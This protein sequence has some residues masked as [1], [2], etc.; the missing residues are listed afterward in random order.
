MKQHFAGYYDLSQEQFRRL[1]TDCVFVVDTNVLLDMYRLSPEARESMYNTLHKLKARLW[2]PYQVAKEYHRNI[3]VVILGQ[4]KKCEEMS[5]QVNQLENKI[6]NG[7]AASRSYPYLSSGIQK[8][9]K[10]L[11]ADINKEIDDEKESIRQLIRQNPAKNQIAE[12]LEGK[13]GGELSV[14][15]IE[16]IYKNGKI[17]YEEKIPP[18]YKDVGEKHGNDV[19]GDLVIWEE[20][21]AFARDNDK[22]IIFIT[23]DVKEDW[24]LRLENETIGPKEELRMEFAHRTN[25]HI[26][27]SYSAASFLK[28]VDKYI[29]VSKIPG[30]II[31]EVASI[32]STKNESVSNDMNSDAYNRDYHFITGDIGRLGDTLSEPSES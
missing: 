3:N 31:D 30:K 2:I 13:I 25:N 1:W 29:E 10:K 21:I 15:R 27:Y 18:G 12:L 5:V 14:E 11:I 4:I 32:V 7:C 17:R 8:R 28:Y 9:I 22:D 16:A 23:S 6:L 26:Y 24:Y 20:M 19:Y